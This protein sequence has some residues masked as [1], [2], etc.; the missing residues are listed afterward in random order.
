MKVTAISDVHVKAP[1]DE[2]DRLLLS[3]LQHPE[4]IS[5]DYVL[6]LGDIFDL[7]CG[8]HE[9]YIRM[10]EHI[11][12]AMDELQKKGKKIFFFEG[13]HDIH[14][15]KLFKK[16]WKKNEVVVCQSPVIQEIDGKLYYFSHGDEHEV[17]N[18]S[19]QRYIHFIR[20]KPMKFVADFIMPFSV[21][22]FLGER[23]SKISRKKGAKFFDVEKVRNRFR[24]GV[25][26]TTKG[27]YDFVLGG[28][29]HVKDQYSL[30]GS[31]SLYLNNGYALKSRTFLLIDNH[32]PRFIPLEESDP[33]LSLV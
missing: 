16:V 33:P 14:L 9:K 26:T 4:V 24:T 20:T 27:S 3:F 1:S 23:A 17:D 29:S 11:F 15:E 10:Y 6:L 12:L 30:P 13:N 7:M 21:L 19:Y 31:S 8:P 5:S 32:C 18:L 28:H 2:A 22:N 25:L